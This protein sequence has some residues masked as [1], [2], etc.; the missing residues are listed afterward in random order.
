MQNSISNDLGKLSHQ[1][2]IQ[3]FWATEVALLIAVLQMAIFSPSITMYLVFAMMFFL[4]SVYYFANKGKQGLASAILLLSLTFMVLVL[5]WVNE[6]IRD[7]VL[8]AFPA[9]VCFSGLTQ[10][11]RLITILFIVMF[12]NIVAITSLNALGVMTHTTDGNTVQS[13]ITI[14]TILSVTTY[15]I[16][17]VSSDL[18]AANQNLVQYKDELEEKVKQ[19]TAELE[20]SLLQ[21][22]ETR[23]QLVE[24][25]K[26]ASLGNMVAGL[27]HEIN[28]PIGIGITAS[29]HLS[30]QAK[31]L[32][33]ALDSNEL[34]KSQA[35]KIVNDISQ[36]ANLIHNNLDR[37]A[38]LTRNFKDAAVEQASTEVTKF[39]VGEKIEEIIENLRPKLNKM[40]H[41]VNIVTKQPVTVYTSEGALVQVINNLVL[42]SVL[43]GFEGREQGHINI[44][45]DEKDSNV[46]VTYQDDGL[47]MAPEVKT[48]VFEPFFTTKRGRG[49]SGLGMHIVYNLVT[50]LLDG[51]I[52]CQS[53]LGHGVQFDLVIP[54]QLLVK[55]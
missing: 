30:E 27:S 53:E 50:Q 42:N 1:R 39:N 46:I 2:T 28:T 22:T 6:G 12:I 4:V 8:Y 45:I 55:A 24:S 51:T 36:C 19:R 41:S 18:S 9:I 49:G 35:L 7:E 34:T 40:N 37:A 13:A 44:T 5:M 10:N 26:M 31:T 43:H 17:L 11:N 47:G 25:K 52:T 21:L 29:S 20:V 32:K 15:A 14:L 3:V 38:N 23:D 48:K 54:K 33:L 16:R